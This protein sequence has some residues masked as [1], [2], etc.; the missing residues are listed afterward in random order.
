MIKIDDKHYVQV[1]YKCLT[2]KRVTGTDKKTLKL[3]YESIGNYKSWE[4]LFDKLLKIYI[5][6]V[7]NS[8][9]ETSLKELKQIFIVSKNQIRD[10]IRQFDSINSN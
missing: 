2:L 6:D 1:E 7:V 9:T 5:A 8:Q 3:T 4:Y 10:L